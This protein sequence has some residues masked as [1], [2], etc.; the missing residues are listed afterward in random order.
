MFTPKMKFI[1]LHAQAYSKNYPF[2]TSLL[3]NV[4]PGVQDLELLP[5]PACVLA[6]D[7]LWLLLVAIPTLN[8]IFCA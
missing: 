3:A 2:T 1:L 7:S 6:L 5:L 4:P 8:S